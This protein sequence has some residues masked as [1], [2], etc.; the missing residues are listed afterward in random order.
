M[1]TWVL[2]SLARGQDEP[3]EPDATVAAQ[4]DA[5]V[6]PQ[7]D[8]T[9]EAA[10]AVNADAEADEAAVAAAN[11]ARVDALARALSKLRALSAAVS[12][13]TSYDPAVATTVTR[14]TLLPAPESADRTQYTNVLATIIGNLEK[15]ATGNTINTTIDADCT[16]CGDSRGCHP[17]GSTEVHVCHKAIAAGADCTLTVLTHEF[18]HRSAGLDDGPKPTTPEQAAVRPDWLAGLT[19]ET[20]YGGTATLRWDY[21]CG[22]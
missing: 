8:A 6:A 9:V 10:G 19:L 3:D 22:R 12:S 17:N 1:I 14:W 7:P 20:A 5:T 11:S 16:K 4:P 21:P 18:F 2:I 13:S 15:N